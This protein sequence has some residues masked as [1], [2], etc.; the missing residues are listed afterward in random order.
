MKRIGLFVGG[1]LGMVSCHTDYHPKYEGE[2]SKVN[3]AI[4]SQWEVF[5]STNSMLPYPFTDALESGLMYYWDLYFIQKGLLLH[6]EEELA[7]S[8]LNNL[9]FQ[10]DSLGFI[11]NAQVSWGMDRSQPPFLSMIVCDYYFHR[12]S[13]ERNKIWLRRAY[14]SCLREYYFWTDTMPGCLED[15]RTAVPGLQRYYHHADSGTLEGVYDA[16][17]GTRFAGYP[18]PL[19]SEEKM[20]FGANVIAECASGYD[21]TPRFQRA[22]IDY[23]PLELNVNLWKYEMNFILLEQEL[24]IEPTK[25]WKACAEHR[26]ALIDRYCWDEARGVFTDYNF[27]KGELNP[28]VSYATFYPLLWE[29][30]D[31]EQA[32]RIFDNL[33][34]LEGECGMAFCGDVDSPITYQWDASSI[35]PPVQYVVY[36]GLANYSYFP[37]ARR[38]ATKYLD[39]VTR[40]FLDPCPDYYE[41]DGEKV[42]RTAG[43]LYEKYDV[44]GNILDKNDYP[45]V[46]MIGW[47]G[48]VFADA[49]EFVT[50]R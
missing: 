42:M 33:S 44:R 48:G 41:T 16:L 49:F 34:L 13:G 35:W 19:T 12:P 47:C 50:G 2:W 6:G 37:A 24:G 17:G 46:T 31:R 30:A 45:S 8:N 11:P 28:V 23:I 15:H 29:M 21:F 14:E 39:L 10:V 27:V 36:R 1:L 43:N 40:N 3:D 5:V 4:A 32:E 18:E 38:I 9:L 7:L 26:K 20:R 22:V 25:D